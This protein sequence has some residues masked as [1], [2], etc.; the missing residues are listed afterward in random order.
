MIIDK[1]TRIMMRMHTTNNGTGLNIYNQY[2]EAMGIN[3]VYVLCRNDNTKPLVE[4]MRAINAV[5]AVTAGFEHASDLVELVDSLS[6]AVKLSQRVGMIVQKN[7][8]LH[9]HY[10]GGEGLMNAIQEKQ[11]ISR[12]HVVIVGSGSVA[13]TL[14]LALM[15]SK[16]IPSQVTVVCRNAKQGVSI[17]QEFGTKVVVRPLADINHI[18]GDVLV[19]ATR[20]GSVDSDELFTSDIVS[21]FETVADVTFG[22]ENTNLIMLARSNNVANIITGWDM[23]THQAVVVLKNIFDHDADIAMLRKFVRLG[24]VTANHGAIVTVNGGAIK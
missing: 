10:Q 5:G 3:A 8:K 7:G 13:K 23:F 4:S 14:I 6:E 9:A 12:K 11:D 16:C 17:S 20:I 22:T 2:F 19:N 21:K 1:D 15:G 18:E 24:L